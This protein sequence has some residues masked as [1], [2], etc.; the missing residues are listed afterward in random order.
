MQPHTMISAAGLSLRARRT[1]CRLF[2]SPVPVTVQVLMTYTSQ[3]WSKSP[4][5]YP[6]RSNS[7]SM[8]WL[9]YWFTLQPRVWKATVFIGKNSFCGGMDGGTKGMGGNVSFLSQERNKEP[10]CDVKVNWI[11]TG[12]G[13]G[14]PPPVAG[15]NLVL[16]GLKQASPSQPFAFPPWSG[17][18][19]PALICDQRAM[20][21]MIGCGNQAWRVAIDEW[22]VKRKPSP[23]RGRWRMQ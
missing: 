19:S 12:S 2:L 16:P 13:P 22:T 20:G 14:H 3:G 23:W 5:W 18:A 9:S 21:G 4:G 1:A 6:A 15:E 17:F 8:A 7:S 11:K 10:V